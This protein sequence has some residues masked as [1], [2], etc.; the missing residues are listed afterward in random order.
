MLIPYVQ[1]S[2]SKKCRLCRYGVSIKTT[3][4]KYCNAKSSHKQWVNKYAWLYPNKTI[5]KTNLLGE[6]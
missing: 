1:E 6:I 4:L 5:Y 2:D 3:Q